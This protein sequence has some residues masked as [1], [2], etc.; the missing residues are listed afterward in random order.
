MAELIMHHSPTNVNT[1]APGKVGFAKILERQQRSRSRDCSAGLR[2]SGGQHSPRCVG[3][4]SRF[5]CGA[6]THL[7]ISLELP[8]RQ[9]LPLL[10]LVQQGPFLY[11]TERSGL[12]IQ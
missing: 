3:V 10:G 2:S 5:G 7:E 11:R 9:T 12:T 1:M 8:Q 6:V 4:R